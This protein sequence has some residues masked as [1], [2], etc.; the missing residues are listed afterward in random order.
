MKL[1]A[2]LLAAIALPGAA[3]AGDLS[4]TVRDTLGRPVAN[5]VV[6]VYPAGGAPRAPARFPWPMTVSQHDLQF[7]PFVLVAP[8]GAVVAFP[9]QDKVRHHVYSF[10]AGN[11]FELKL[12]GREQARTV[13]FKAAGVAAIGCNIH[14]QMVGF[15]KVVDT[16]FAIKTGIDGVALIP[17]LPAGAATARVWHP[18]MRAKDNEIAVAVNLPAQGV[19][20]HESRVEMR[21]NAPAQHQMKM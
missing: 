16:P 12:Y 19:L 17:A 15:I 18:S 10:S 20:R 2:L 13:T 7:D 1:I 8:V 4:L 5:A 9:N 6:T 3:L 21:P 11:R 14:D